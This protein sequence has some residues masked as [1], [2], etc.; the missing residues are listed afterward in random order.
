M[1]PLKTLLQQHDIT[2]TAVAVATGVSPATISQMINHNI[3]PKKNKTRAMLRSRITGFL[4]QYNIAFEFEVTQAEAPARVDVTSTDTKEEHP[5]LLAKQVLYPAAK[6][7]FSL[8][9]DPFYKE[10]QSADDVF[11]SPDIRYVREA[12]Y[13]TARHG[14]FMAVVGESGSGKSTLRRD[15]IERIN[16]ENAPII[17]IEPFTIA[18]EDNDL[19]GKTLK[20][21]HIAEAIINTVQPLEVIKRSSEAKFR[22]LQRVLK[23]SSRAGYSHILII[24]EAHSLPLATLKHLKRF[25]ELEDGFKKLLSIVLIGQSELGLK[26]SQ[27]NH[28]VREVVQ[29]CEVVELLPLNDKLEEYLQFKFSR[30][31]KIMTDVLAEDALEAIKARL[32]SQGGRRGTVSLL[33]PLAVGNLITAAMNLAAEIGSPTVTADVIKGL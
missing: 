8:Y 3:W 12:L 13:L 14:G 4:A 31:G 9:R 21:S 30:V 16:R 26:L 7:H 15:L 11:T 29:R 2:Q 5:M 6:K 20:A 33:H 24:E 32:T 23:E 28:N 18:M 25:F 22:Q 17:V 19:Q 27:R 1:Q 10:V